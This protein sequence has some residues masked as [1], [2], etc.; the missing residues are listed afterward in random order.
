METFWHRAHV[1]PAALR[2][3]PESLRRLL[4]GAL[5][6]SLCD[7]TV[8]LREFDESQSLAGIL[9]LALVPGTPAGGLPLARVAAH[10][11]E[12]RFG[13]RICHSDERAA[14]KQ[15]RG[16]GDDGALT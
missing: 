10:T 12:L 13:G 2:V 15:R 8:A 3:Q 7:I 1:R 11:T 6:F 4:C 14:E 5:R 16:R 9:S